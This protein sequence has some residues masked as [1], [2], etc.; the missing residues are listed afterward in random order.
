MKRRDLSRQIAAI[1]HTPMKYTQPIAL[2]AAHLTLSVPH[3]HKT[4]CLPAIAAALLIGCE[5]Q[6][7]PAPAAS[8]TPAQTSAA[9]QNSAPV[10]YINGQPVT[11][12]DLHTRLI[13]VS[14]GQVLSELILDNM[15]RDRLKQRGLTLTPE[16]IDAEESHMRNTL[17]ADPN[18]ATRLLIKMFSDRGLGKLGFQS[19]LFRNAGLR[20]LIKDQVQVPETLLRQAYEL[21]H[22]QRYRIRI[23]VTDSLPQASD[24]QARSVAGESFAD[25][26]SLNSTDASAAQGG[27]LSPISPV[28][29][30]YPKALRQTLASMQ[31]GTISDLIAVDD[32]FIIMK[33]EKILPADAIPFEQARAQLEY[34]VQLELE[35]Q[36]MQQAARSMLADAKVVVLEPVLNKSWLN[37]KAKMQTE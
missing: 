16:L 14:G 34:T 4:V 5:S 8:T 17:S 37:Q 12:S 6:P 15:I 36:R 7:L 35:G 24:L 27:L 3:M 20:L 13:E 32:H 30:T 26:A 10:A 25:L 23:I 18:E 29:N 9:R 11:R 33:L 1:H 31:T 2:T 21:R 28:D 19:M 22:G